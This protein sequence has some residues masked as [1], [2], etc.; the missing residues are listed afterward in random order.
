MPIQSSDVTVNGGT[1]TPPAQGPN[2]GLILGIKEPL[3]VLRTLCVYLSYYYCGLL[4]LHQ[5]QIRTT[6]RRSL[7]ERANWKRHQGRI[8]TE[9]NEH[10]KTS[11][12]VIFLNRFTIYT[13]LSITFYQLTRYYY[14]LDI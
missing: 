4:H 1:I 9:L 5:D 11:L 14:L 7:H 13:T 2:L 10:R 8:R 3:G 12:I 6:Q